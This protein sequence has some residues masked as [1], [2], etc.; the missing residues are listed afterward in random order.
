M[1]KTGFHNS[2]RADM[3]HIFNWGLKISD[4]QELFLVT[5]HGHGGYSGDPIEQTKAIQ[6]D[7]LKIIEEAGFSINDI[8]RTEWTFVKSVTDQEAE[9]ITKLWAEF[10]KDVHPKPAAGT[11]RYV[12]RLASPSMKVE[13]EL[14]LAR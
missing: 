6:K 7:Q 4:F 3:R 5:G 2:D 9:E 10:L 12:D 13:F 1:K 8:I 11:L 14:L